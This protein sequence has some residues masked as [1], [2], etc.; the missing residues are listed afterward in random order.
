MDH[1]IKERNRKKKKSVKIKL[2]G[3]KIITQMRIMYAYK[4]VKVFQFFHSARYSY[5]DNY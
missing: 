5:E 3:S 4:S 1:V 2:K